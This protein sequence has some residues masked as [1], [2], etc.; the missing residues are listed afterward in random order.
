VVS[1][2][3]KTR[4]EVFKRDG[5]RCAYCGASVE[6]PDVILEA[7]HIHPKSKGGTDGID[8]LITSCKTC[9]RGKSAVPLSDIP[10]TLCSRIEEVKARQ[11]QLAGYRALMEMA[12]EVTKAEVER[13]Q[14]AFQEY[15]P[16][17][18]FTDQF[19]KGSVRRFLKAVPAQ[20]LIGY[21]HQAGRKIPD[22]P[23]RTIKYFCGICWR[24]IREDYE[25]GV[26]AWI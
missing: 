26:G 18:V 24:H 23:G 14:R 20:V 5:F 19:V 1:I 22:D 6:E 25:G 13:I 12:E 2:S 17:K 10:E 21:V 3:K 9:N 11:T 15:Y 16:D 7:D 8:N 4:F